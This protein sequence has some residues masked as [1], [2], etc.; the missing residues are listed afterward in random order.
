MLLFK[1]LTLWTCYKWMHVTKSEFS[2]SGS[3]HTHRPSDDSDHSQ[4]RHHLHPPLFNH[5]WQL[6]VLLFRNLTLWTCYK[7]RH[8]VKSIFSFSGSVH[9]H[10]PSDD[11]DHSQS[12]H[13]SHPPLFNHPWQTF[14]VVPQDSKCPEGGQG[15]LHVPSQYRSNGIQSWILRC[16]GY[17]HMLYISIFH[18]KAN[19]SPVVWHMDM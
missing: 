7:W 1:N 15:V 17:V 3:I 6:F 16:S 8:V 12:R 14:Y 9:T 11:S 5:P 2:F 13:H 10:W 18:K 4:S 19:S